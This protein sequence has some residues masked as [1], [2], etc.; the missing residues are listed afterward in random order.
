MDQAQITVLEYPDN[1]RLR[2][3]MYLID[4]NHCLQEIIDNSV[5]E[6]SAGRCNTIKIEV[7]P[8][9]DSKFPM[10]TVTDNGGGI[11]TSLS[12]DPKYKNKTQLYLALSKT[13]SGAKFGAQTGYKT[14]TS[15]LHGVGAACVNAVSTYFEAEV[16]HDKTIS[17]ILF[18]RGLLVNEKYNV[19]YNGTI[20]HG[21]KISFVLDDT[22]W[23]NDEYDFS[24]VLSRLEQLSYLNPKLKFIF[25]DKEKNYEFYHEHGL[26]EYFQNIISTKSMLDTNPVVITKVVNNNEVG[27]IRIDIALGYSNGYSGEIYS[28]VNNVHT[29]S[30]DHV[31]GFNAGV[32]KAIIGYYSSNEKYKSLVKSL[33]SED[34]K[35]GLI[36]LISVKVMSP[37]F[38]GQSKASIKMPEVRA[39]VSNLVNDELKFYLER[40]PVFSKALGDK[41][42]K[43][44]KARIAAKRAREAIRNVK[45]SLEASMPAKLMA[46]SNKKPEESEIFLVEGDSAA[47][48]AGQARDPKCQAILPVFGKILN[49]EKSREDEVLNNSKLLEVIKALKCNIGKGFDI[50]KI[51]YHKIIIMADAD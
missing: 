37:K 15:G 31:T 23:K 17:N 16:I 42:E 8:S 35:E 36:A 20:K 46:C 32:S 26:I 6:Y 5:D 38:E 4:A 24:K 47:G 51:R 30:G 25:K 22:L 13:H 44:A 2:K 49:T 29:Q 18:N 10:L 9:K 3:E 45:N 21:T 40:H 50:N 7:K 14:M 28:F 34:T 39:A 12:T 1:V 48:S 27:D 43:A 11:P 33:T 19:P 41:L